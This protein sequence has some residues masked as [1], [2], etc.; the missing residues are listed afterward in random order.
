MTSE[1]LRNHRKRLNK[2]QKDLASLLGISLKA[3]SSYEQGR[4]II[5]S[6]IERQML[7]LISH[8]R[9]P[10]LHLEKCWKVLACPKEK[11]EKCPAWEFKSGT[12]CWLIN[13]TICQGEPQKNWDDKIKFCYE[14]EVL[15]RVLAD[16]K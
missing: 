9:S 8:K 7:F 14:C 2:T 3:V 12:H 16:D 1:D 11:R 4:R 13:G 10:K 5:P 15:K 6:H